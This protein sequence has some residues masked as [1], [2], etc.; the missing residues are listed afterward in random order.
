MTFQNT[1]AIIATKS[2]KHGFKGSEMIR[3]QFLYEVQKNR[4]AK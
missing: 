3:K 4:R 2:K 1:Q